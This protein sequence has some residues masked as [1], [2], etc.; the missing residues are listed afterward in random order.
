MEDGYDTYFENGYIL[1]ICFVLSRLF[2]PSGRLPDRR[3]LHQRH[4]PHLN[5]D[6]RAEPNQVLVLH[7]VTVSR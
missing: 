3:L 5:Q 6:I 7:K 2:Q 4:P 1:N